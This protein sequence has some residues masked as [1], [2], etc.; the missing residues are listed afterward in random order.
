MP[1]ASKTL[2]FTKENNDFS[3][4]AEFGSDATLARHVRRFGAFWDA[5]DSPFRVLMALLS[6]PR[7][8]K[9]SLVGQPGAP[10]A[11]MSSNRLSEDLETTSLHP[12]TDA[13]ALPKRPKRPSWA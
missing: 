6:L 13:A 4:R 10:K 12:K 2:L 3:K 11:P 1:E 9:F 7:A 5:S 8:Q